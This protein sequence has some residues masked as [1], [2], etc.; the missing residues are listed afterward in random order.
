MKKP[1]DLGIAKNT[2]RKN[3]KL[4]DKKDLENSIL[5]QLRSEKGYTQEQICDEL[6]ITADTYREYEYEPQKTPADILCKLADLYDKSIDYLLGRTPYSHYENKEISEMTGLSDK[7]IELLRFIKKSIPPKSYDENGNEIEYINL[8]PN[9][10]YYDENGNEKE[11]LKKWYEHNPEENNKILEVVNYIL[12][13]SEIKE[14]SKGKYIFN[15]FTLLYEYIFVLPEMEYKTDSTN[16][17]AYIINCINS[18]NGNV[19]PLFTEKLLKQVKKDDIN[20]LLDMYQEEHEK[21][22]YNESIS[23]SKLDEIYRE[24][25]KGIPFFKDI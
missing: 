10:K 15:L 2:D 22:F 5:Y 7:S 14:Y 4:R 12:S 16:V 25:H 6:H 13:K 20:R 19:E 1:K 21:Q 17:N 24:N 3:K 11:L 18:N 23:L 9:V 8:P